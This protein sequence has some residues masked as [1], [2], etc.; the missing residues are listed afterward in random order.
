MTLN[1]STGVISGTPSG[2]A[3]NYTFTVTATNPYG[4]GS[5]TGTQTLVLAAGGATKLAFSATPGTT[6]NGVTFAPSRW[7]RSKTPAAPWSDRLVR[8][9]HPVHRLGHGTL[10]CTTNPVTAVS[11]VA[12]FA[13]WRS[14]A[15]PATSR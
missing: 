6:A 15:R 12:T 11:G 10:N 7:S 8:F 3:G 5:A 1:T 4:T 13:G 14:P 9:R 2:T